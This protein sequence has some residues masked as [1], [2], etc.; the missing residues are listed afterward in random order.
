MPPAV[1][2][3]KIPLSRVAVLIGPKGKTKKEL[4]ERGQCRVKVESKT[5]NVN[6]EGEDAASLLKTANIVHAIGR[7][8]SPEHAFKLFQEDKYFELLDL[9]ELIGQDPHALSA[10]RGR[11]IGRNGSIR[12]KIEEKTDC[13][14]SV[15]GKTIALIGKPE[16]L[17]R[18]KK[19]VEMLLEGASHVSMLKYL[20]RMPREE[21]EFNLD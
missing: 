15:Q 19:A 18:A 1:E 4:E 9:A 2:Y 3:V 12:E 21:P 6:V 11:V 17:E 7:G 8:F 14:V 20:D 16:D 5:G 10:K 13:L